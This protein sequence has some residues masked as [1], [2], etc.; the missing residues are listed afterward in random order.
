MIKYQ[1]IHQS[2]LCSKPSKCPPFHGIKPQVPTVA[3]EIC[4]TGPA[5]LSTAPH[6]RSTTLCPPIQVWSTATSPSGL[7]KPSPSASL[8]WQVCSSN[9][10]CFS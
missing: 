1:N 6:P 4:P 3:C 8:P 5:L 2:L 10:Y 9:V 7:L